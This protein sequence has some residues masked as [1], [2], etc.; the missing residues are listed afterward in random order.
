MTAI[1]A[2]IGLTSLSTQAADFVAG[3]DY[4]VLANPEKLKAIK[5]LF[6]NFL[7]WLPT[8]LQI[9]TLHG[10]VVKKIARWCGVYADASCDE[11][12][13]ETKRAR[14]Y[15]AQLLGYQGKTHQA[16][17]DAIQKDRQNCLTKPLSA[18]GTHQRRGY[19]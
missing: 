11:P 16:M 19:Q 10:T 9:R 5:S 4:K 13:V 12:C 7:V 15:A 17:F 1:A 3:Q 8:L 14:F 18:N 6:A 2:A